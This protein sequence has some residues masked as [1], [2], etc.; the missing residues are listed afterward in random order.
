MKKNHGSKAQGTVQTRFEWT[1]LA[2]EKG[3][4]S[5]MEGKQWSLEQQ[6]QQRTN[7]CGVG[8]PSAL[9]AGG[10]HLDFAFRATS[11][12][13]AAVVQTTS[14]TPKLLQIFSTVLAFGAF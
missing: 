3:K 14:H 8:R 2:I 9:L 10:A 4:S 1:L 11:A 6:A 13:E 12:G 7:W 5:V